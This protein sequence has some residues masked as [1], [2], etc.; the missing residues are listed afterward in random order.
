MKVQIFLLLLKKKMNKNKKVDKNLYII[1]K[2][3]KYRIR[4]FKTLNINFGPQ[5]PAAHGVLRIL[6][7]LKGEIIKKIDPHII[8]H[9]FK[10]Y[11]ILID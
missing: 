9:I 10:V 11:L 8:N 4:S 7:E 1:K 3:S 2:N 6:L 5:H